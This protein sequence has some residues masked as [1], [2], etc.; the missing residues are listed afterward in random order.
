[1]L[2]GTVEEARKAGF[3]CVIS[4][5]STLRSPFVTSAPRLSSANTAATPPSELGAGAGGVPGAG[6]GGGG[7]PPVA[8]AALYSPRGI[9]LE[10]FN[11]WCLRQERSSTFG[12]QLNP[13]VWYSTLYFL[14][15]SNKPMNAR[16]HSTCFVSLRGVL[17][18]GQRR[19]AS[20]DVLVFELLDHPIT[21]EFCL[22]LDVLYERPWCGLLKKASK[23]GGQHCC[24]V[25]TVTQLTQDA[26]VAITE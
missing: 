9:P 20:F 3:L 10:E 25:L 11:D 1:M 13:V 22:L 18:S 12:F 15:S 5:F 26:P 19:V 2:L 24:S 7:A 23:K 17:M 6:G 8:N 4:L 16:T 14:I 21:I